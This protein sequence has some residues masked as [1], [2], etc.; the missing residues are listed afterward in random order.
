M[1][2]WRNV[3]DAAAEIG[4]KETL[5]RQRLRRICAAPH[6]RVGPDETLQVDVEWFDS[7]HKRILE[8]GFGP[9]SP[10]ERIRVDRQTQSRVDRKRRL[11]GQMR[12]IAEH[13]LSSFD[14]LAFDDDPGPTVSTETSQTFVAPLP[15]DHCLPARVGAEPSQFVDYL[16]ERRK[17]A[18]KIEQIKFRKMAVEIVSREAVTREAFEV[19]RLARDQ[20]L[21]IPD[22]VSGLLAGE[23]SQDKIFKILD[24]EIRRVLSDLCD[25]IEKIEIDD[26]VEIT[27]PMPKEEV[28]T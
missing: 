21:A 13:D 24:G 5:L 16:D 23:T 10:A 25:Q 15:P 9:K 3:A 26:T 20:M 12:P 6:T 1:T 7:D 2:R 18:A 27:D 11:A 8:K 14:D 19:A 4:I 28:D 17:W 22:R